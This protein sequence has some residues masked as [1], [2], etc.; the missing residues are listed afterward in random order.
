MKS[1][2]IM[3]A[4]AAFL[5]SGISANAEGFNENPGMGA[6]RGR[7]VNA[8]NEILPGASIFI[9][10]LKTGVTSDANGFYNFS[11]IKPGS[12]NIIISYVGYSPVKTTITNSSAS[13]ARGV[14]PS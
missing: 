3:C 8:E 1:K 11:N 6:I 10:E 12:Y 5:L 9:E 7:V 4:T 14:S 13:L 2:T